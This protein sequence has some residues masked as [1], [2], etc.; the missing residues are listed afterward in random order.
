MSSI[1]YSEEATEK[2]NEADA[3]LNSAIEKLKNPEESVEIVEDPQEDIEIQL[4]E[5]PEPEKKEPRR[6]E[7]VETDD[8]KVQERIND[9]YGQAKNSDARNQALIEHNQALEAR[10]SEVL[11]RQDKF[12]ADVKSTKSDQVEGEIK[13]RL[14]QARSD[15][16]YDTVDKLENDLLDIRLERRI[17]QRVAAQ[18]KSKQ[19]PQEA[20]Q[21][22]PDQMYAFH[23]G[24]EKDQQGNLVRPWLQDWHPDNEK[25]INTLMSIRG[26]L[27]NAG[28]QPDVRAMFSILD[29]RMKGGAK[30][31]Q[32]AAVLP[33]S[34]TAHN[35]KKVVKLT[36]QEAEIARRMGI[37]PEAYAR[38]KTMLN[39]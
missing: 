24:S 13:E 39:R 1:Q 35:P 8:P 36:K 27:E 32:E 31:R 10:L 9:L 4:E 34:D 7:F 19:Q 28:K 38:Q 29:E 16:D 12:E 23:L 30:P 3:T 11:E 6:T 17:E 14:R 15:G 18:P 21:T 33:S 22:S 26:E 25:A 37:S 20:L 2:L 5:A